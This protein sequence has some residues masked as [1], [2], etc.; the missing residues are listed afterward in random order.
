[1]PEDDNNLLRKARDRN[2]ADVRRQ[3][4]NAPEGAPHLLRGKASLD[5]N[6]DEV[7]M[8]RELDYELQKRA[9]LNRLAGNEED[10][11]AVARGLQ[12][13]NRLAEADTRE[14]VEQLTAQRALVGVFRDFSEPLRGTGSGGQGRQVYRRENK[15]QGGVREANV[16]IAVSKA[17]ALIGS[18]ISTNPTATITSFRSV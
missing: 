7:Q 11:D 17:G 3:S 16:P 10:K 5:Q 12:P 18:E 14:G 4:L 9:E 2:L 8:K 1:M 15:V 13:K 6:V